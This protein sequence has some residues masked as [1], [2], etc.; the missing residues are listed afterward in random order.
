MIKE[1]IRDKCLVQIREI[2]QELGLSMDNT[3]RTSYLSMLMDK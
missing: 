2:L 3:V 1:N